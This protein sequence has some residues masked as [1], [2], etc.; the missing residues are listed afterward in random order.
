MFLPSNKMSTRVIQI[1]FVLHFL[2]DCE[3]RLL[4]VYACKICED[5]CLVRHINVI[6][7]IIRN[8]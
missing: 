5:C 1:V 6:F 2:T 7:L 8:V 4:A 3:T